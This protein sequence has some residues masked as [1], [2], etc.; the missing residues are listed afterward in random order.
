MAPDLNPVY[1][2]TSGGGLAFC[3]MTPVYLAVLLFFY[4][5]V[6]M[7]LMRVTALT[8]LIIALY[9]ILVNFILLPGCSGGT[10]FF[11]YLSCLSLFMH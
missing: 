9:N 10:G 1:I 7:P 11:I 5:E 6:N 4:P 8:G 3:M 2:L